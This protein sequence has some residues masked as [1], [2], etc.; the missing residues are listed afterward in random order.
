MTTN[1]TKKSSRN[2]EATK[3]WS[4]ASSKPIKKHIGG[5]TKKKTYFYRIIHP[6]GS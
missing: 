5:R 6:E 1:S 2:K 3:L 4:Y